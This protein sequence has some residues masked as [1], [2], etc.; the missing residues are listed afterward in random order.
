[1][2]QHWPCSS[3][4]HSLLATTCCKISLGGSTTSTGACAHIECLA[5]G[6]WATG[7]SNPI[8]WL[9]LPCDGCRC[10]CAC[11]DGKHIDTDM[12]LQRHP[13]V[14]AAACLQQT[15]TCHAHSAMQYG[16]GRLVPNVG[17]MQ[18]GLKHAGVRILWD[19]ACLPS[20]AAKTASCSSKACT[21]AGCCQHSCCLADEVLLR[22]CHTP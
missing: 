2:Q 18:E 21:I 6:T 14:E 12:Q 7:C 1:M 20:H 22:A 19:V 5:G 4:M 9:Q 8:H 13:A 15:G 3:P 16:T 10:S 11:T 17:L